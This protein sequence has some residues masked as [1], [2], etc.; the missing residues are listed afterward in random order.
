MVAPISNAL[1]TMLGPVAECF[2][3]ES[4]ER[5]A[6]LQIAPKTLA[7]IQQLAER[8][9]EG[10]LSDAERAEYH[11]YVEAMDIVAILQAKARESL[12]RRIDR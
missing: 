3:R 8:A 7:R 11:E 4:A 5:L 9:N 10:T 6:S 12:A 2:D 1:E